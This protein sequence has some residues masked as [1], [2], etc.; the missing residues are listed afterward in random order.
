MRKILKI[1]MVLC[2]IALV[3]F[4]FLVGLSYVVFSPKSSD[5]FTAQVDGLEGEIQIVYYSNFTKSGLAIYYCKGEENTRIGEIKSGSISL[6]RE[7][8]YSMSVD[9]NTLLIRWPPDSS[10]AEENWYEKSFTLPVEGE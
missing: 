10:Y 1:F 3:C 4:L 9:G 7:G 6:F 2:V 5:P 8:K